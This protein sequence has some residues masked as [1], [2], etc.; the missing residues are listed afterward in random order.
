MALI[1]NV[2]VAPSL[3]FVSLRRLTLALAAVLIAVSAISFG[4]FGLN[5]GVDFRGGIVIQAQTTPETTLA[6]MRDRL[7]QLDL[8]D[9]NIQRFGEAH[10]VLIRVQEQAGGEDAQNAAIEQVKE[11]LQPQVTSYERTEFVGPQVGEELKQAGML[12]TGL[13]L[14]AMAAYIWFRF[15]WQF[16]VAA[17]AAL[18]HDVITT[19]GFFSI[20]QLQFNLGT[21]A[22]VLTIAGYS[23]NDTVVVFDR[24]RETVRRYKRKPMPE[25]LNMAVNSTITRTV[26][27]STTTLVALIALAVFG[28]AVIR[29]FTWALIW[30]VLIGTFSSIG[31][32]VPLLLQMRLSPSTLVQE[33]DETA[34]Q[35]AK[36]A[37]SS[38]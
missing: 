6:G 36:A 3:N 10:T 16:A 11:H 4:M 30:G 9:T 32:A 14:L 33:E 18:I 38:S 37:G 5:L 2:P 19:I 1:R 7:A 8:G 28:G 17:L 26:L 20:T 21:V 15:E 23:I 25:L 13:A 24:V 34:K 29:S 31:V 22:A 27:T 12:A 35:Q